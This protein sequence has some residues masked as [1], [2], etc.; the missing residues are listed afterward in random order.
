MRTTGQ[1]RHVHTIQ[2]VPHTSI[3]GP[4]HAPSDGPGSPRSIS[5]RSVVPR[6]SLLLKYKTL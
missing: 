3:A 5:R 4:Q 1:A 2:G 6:D